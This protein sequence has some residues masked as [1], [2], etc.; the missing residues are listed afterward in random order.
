MEDIRV[1]EMN[2]PIPGNVIQTLADPNFALN[3]LRKM[4][5]GKCYKGAFTISV[6]EVVRMGDVVISRTSRASNASMTVAFKARVKT[7]AIGTIIGPLKV[8]QYASDK[9]GTKRTGI[10]SEVE[11][12]NVFV[13]YTSSLESLQSG[14]EIFGVI[15]AIQYGTGQSIMTMSADLFV[16][17]KS[18][19][20]IKINWTG[21]NL[22][23][24][25]ILDQINRARDELNAIPA[26]TVER[27]GKLLNVNNIPDNA[28]VIG[29]SE[30]MSQKIRP[31][32]IYL[33]A[34]PQIDKNVYYSSK[35]NGEFEVEI[36]ATEALIRIS[37]YMLSYINAYIKHCAFVDEFVKSGKHK[38][39]FT[40]YKQHLLSNKA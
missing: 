18:Y 11:N 29:I 26:T 7:Y 35:N 36:G 32:Y 30:L 9:P 39:L 1:Y 31:V 23:Y 2:M 24:S 13:E 4:Y 17:N 14:S 16:P 22:H 3:I 34:G 8:T 19:E 15:N 10:I 20:C 12:G 27:V 6:I 28:E 38:V 5:E 21:Y 33:K 37:Q 40:I 25:D